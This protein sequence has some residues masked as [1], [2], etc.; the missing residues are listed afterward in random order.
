MATL[1]VDIYLGTQEVEFG[2]NDNGGDIGVSFRIVDKKDIV[3]TVSVG[4]EVRRTKF[5]NS[6]YIEPHPTIPNMYV[7]NTKFGVKLN[8][9]VQVRI[10][11]VYLE[12]Y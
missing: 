6:P 4:N 5:G 2:I 7:I 3:V 9:K 12:N 10:N 11:C 8:D 1:P